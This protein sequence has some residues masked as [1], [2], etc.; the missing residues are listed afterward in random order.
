VILGFYTSLGGNNT[1]AYLT[2]MTVRVRELRAPGLNLDG[3]G[4]YPCGENCP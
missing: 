3:A 1:M 4:N 2:M